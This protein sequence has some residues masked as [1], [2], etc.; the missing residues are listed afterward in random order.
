MRDVIIMVVSEQRGIFVSSIFVSCPGICKR[1]G[2]ITDGKSVEKSHIHNHNLQQLQQ[3]KAF[4]FRKCGI[5]DL[6]FFSFKG[7]L[8]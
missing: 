5:L 3:K 6:D 8:G 7:L 2:K 4:S 1:L